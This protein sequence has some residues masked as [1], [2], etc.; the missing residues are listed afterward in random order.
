M[1]SFVTPKTGDLAALCLASIALLPAHARAQEAP[2]PVESAPPEA[3]TPRLGLAVKE[4]GAG[5]GYTLLIGTKT[6]TYLIDGD[7]QKIHVWD[8][9]SVSQKSSTKLLR[10]DG[11]LLALIHATPSLVELDKDGDIV[12]KYTHTDELHHDFTLMPN[13]NILTIARASKTAAEMI[14]AGAN[15]DYV[16]RDH[17]TYDY[18]FELKPN[19]TGGEQQAGEAPAG[20][21]VWTWSMWDH[22]IQDFDPKRPNYGDVAQHPERIDI[23]ALLPR[24]LATPIGS[25]DRPHPYRHWAYINVLLPKLSAKPP[26]RNWAHTN[27]V[28]YNAELDQVML[29][30]RNFSEVWIIDHST[31]T[32]QAAGRSG[33]NSGRGGDLLYRWGNP[34]IYRAGTE[35]DQLLFFPHQTHWIAEGLPGA[36]NILAFSNGLEF[37]GRERFYS[38]GIELTPPWDGRR[39]RRAANEAYGPVAP[40]WIYPAPG[41]ASFYSPTQSGIQRLSNGNTLLCISN[42]GT[43]LEVTPS[44]TVVWKYV[45]PVTP[46]GVLHQGDPM[47]TRKDVRG[48]HQWHN[49]LYRAQRIPPD[50]PGL[51]TLDLTPK[52]PIERYRQP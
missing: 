43:V 12:W 21:V 36:G 17:Y 41:S 1:S 49:H 10:D 19:R 20:E 32:E 42:E 3:P 31:T 24:F 48:W 9:S 22:L 46:E 14:A 44:G 37:P 15:P 50:H 45:S 51:R 23:N 8:T 29:S 5:V 33:G 35:D 39:Y 28:D 4:E 6:P 52:G 7:G 26:Y 40:A 27:A 16:V 13:G 2:R 25:P 11:R 30:A 38:S 18:I 47:P 34:R